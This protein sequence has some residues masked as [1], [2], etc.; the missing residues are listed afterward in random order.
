MKNL[1]IDFDGVILDTMTKSY[2]ELE[3]EG[4]DKKNQEQVMEFFRNID[5]ERLISE[6]E[7]INDSINEIK[8]ICASKKFN[9]YILTHVNS[10]NEMIEKIKYLHKA[11]PQV[12]VVSVPKEIPKTE[13]VNPS[14]AILVDDYSGNIKEWQKKLGIGIKFVKE[15]EGSDYPEIT[16]LSE[17]IDMFS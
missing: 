17:V 1:Y 16:H 11:L 8:K 5:W 2:K 10:T 13:V 9:V 14:A 6:T 4:I 12:T 3:K 15:L 7:Q